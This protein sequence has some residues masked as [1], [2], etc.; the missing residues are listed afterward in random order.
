[1]KPYNSPVNVR[2]DQANPAMPGPVITLSGVALA[3]WLLPVLTVHASYLLSATAGLIPLCVPYID[4]CTS[5]SA[6]GRYGGAYFLFKVGMLPAAVFVG[7]FWWLCRHWLLALGDRDGSALRAIVLVGILA[8]LF[9]ALYTVFLGS[10][11]EFYSFMR[12]FGG[13]SISAAATS[14]NCCCWRD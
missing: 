3:T 7:V 14:R 9:L 10:R 5:I 1:M 8:A 6:S 11:G 13:S 2:S 12:R 4:G